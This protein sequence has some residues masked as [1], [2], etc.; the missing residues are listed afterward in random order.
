MKI[1]LFV[2]FITSLSAF[3]KNHQTGIYHL[4][5][6][7][8]GRKFMDI[9][10]IDK[11]AADQSIE[12]TLEVVDRFK[13]PLKGKIDAKSIS[14]NFTINEGRGDFDVVLKATKISQCKVKGQ[15]L[16]AEKA[17]GI[18]EGQKVGCHE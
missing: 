16:H 7:I 4:N 3:A 8:S 15:L 12:G 18:F 14:A 5:V 11:I 1:I 13:V 6:D 9:L 10:T 2:I 17:F